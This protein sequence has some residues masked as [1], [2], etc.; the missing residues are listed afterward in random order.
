[1]QIAHALSKCDSRRLYFVGK[2]AILAANC[3][4]CVTD[5]DDMTSNLSEFIGNKWADKQ[6][7]MHAKIMLGPQTAWSDAL[8]PCKTKCMQ[9]VHTLD[10]QSILSYSTITY[11][12]LLSK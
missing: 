8:R 12:G 6:S 10:R 5:R 4:T 11:C 3:L 2:S 7:E 1:M 9:T